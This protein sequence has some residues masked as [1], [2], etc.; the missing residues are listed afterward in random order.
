MPAKVFRCFTANT[1]LVGA[2]T[3]LYTQAVCNK[4]VKGCNSGLESIPHSLIC[5]LVIMTPLDPLTQ[6]LIC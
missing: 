5:E 4:W 6:L 2:F 1:H 3:V